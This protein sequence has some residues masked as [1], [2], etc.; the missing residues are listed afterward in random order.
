MTTTPA[1]IPG[2]KRRLLTSESCHQ[3]EDDNDEHS[4]SSDPSGNKQ[5]NSATSDLASHRPIVSE[6]QQ[7]AVLKQL[8]AGDESNSMRYDR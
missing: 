6:R 1:T 3:S 4:N 8:T 5:R 2:R 7:L